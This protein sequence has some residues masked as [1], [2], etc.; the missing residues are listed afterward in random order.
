MASFP[1]EAR[2]QRHQRFCGRAAAQTKS[3]IFNRCDLP[4]VF[5]IISF[6]SAPFCALVQIYPAAIMAMEPE[7]PAGIIAAQLH[8]RGVACAAPREATRDLRAS[9]PH[10]AI[11]TLRCDEALYEV[12]LFPRTGARIRPLSTAAGQQLGV[13]CGKD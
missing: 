3:Q 13:R 9:K 8:R 4:C 10:E 6:C 12:R 1:I 2:G 11:W 5:T 7:T